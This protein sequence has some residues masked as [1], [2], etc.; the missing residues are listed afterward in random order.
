MTSRSSPPEDAP[1]SVRGF[2]PSS[3]ADSL[4]EP[5]AWRRAL[6]LA[7]VLLRCDEQATHVAVLAVSRL[8]S[9]LRRQTNRLRYRPK[10]RRTK[11]WRS[12][13]QML[14]QLVF[15]ATD[16]WERHH[17]ANDVK[18]PNGN[19]LLR[20]YVR[21]LVQTAAQRNALH[22]GVAVCSVLHRYTTP[23][24]LAVL[25][26]IACPKEGHWDESYLRGR[27]RLLLDETHARFAPWLDLESGRCGTR[28]FRGRPANADERATVRGTLE[29]LTPWD[30]ACEPSGLEE[31][32]QIHRL[33]HPRSFE[34]LVQRLGLDTVGLWAP[35]FRSAPEISCESHA[36][37]V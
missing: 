20:R 5:D 9:R 2:V 29:T 35:S 26:D 17:E 14:Q 32:A 21:F 30:T 11:V 33:I 13:L 23:E 12:R 25:D 34:R 10:G 8:E 22:V 1:R 7:R 3:S 15:E 16:T 18:P 24:T 19:V 28:R 36:P 4:I 6:E 31:M 27:K 37:G